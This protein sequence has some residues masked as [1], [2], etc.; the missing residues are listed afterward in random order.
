MLR[1][2]S[3]FWLARD[4]LAE[5]EN[6]LEDA[7]ARIPDDGSEIRL[8]V[9]LALGEIAMR[10]GRLE[11]AR[12]SVERWLRWGRA[13]GDAS[14]VA[15]ALSSLASIS[16]RE[17]DFATSVALLEEAREVSLPVD[18]AR[19]HSNI[20]GNLGYALSGVGQYERAANFCRESLDL[21]PTASDA[22]IDHANLGL[23][24]LG[25]R[26]IEGASYHY[27]LAIAQSVESG[28]FFTL[29]DALAGAAAIALE[30]GAPRAALAILGAT[31]SLR[32]ELGITAEPLEHDLGV[33]T[34]QVARSILRTEDAAEA[35]KEGQLL[36]VDRVVERA[37]A[38]ID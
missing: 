1:A 5:G 23:A 16:M 31:F 4:H 24:L 21:S 22:S 33:R 19:L 3:K 32:S 17:A 35:W 36:T 28:Y 9:E 14:E 27:R 11:A 7:L 26:D 8:R 12:L 29:A 38:S 30:R 2:L 37:L 10:R 13:K 6:L 34:D 18:D 20:V 25:L 15:Y